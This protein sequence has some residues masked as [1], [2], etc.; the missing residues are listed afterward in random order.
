MSELGSK[1]AYEG[2]GACLWKVSVSVR[3]YEAVIVLLYERCPKIPIG[4]VMPHYLP[5]L[6]V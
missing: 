4:K 2:P 5:S 3:I 1:S 6:H